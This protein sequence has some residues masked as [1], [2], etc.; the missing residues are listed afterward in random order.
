MQLT[1]RQILLL[2]LLNDTDVAEAAKLSQLLGVS[3][4][5]LKTELKALGPPLRKY[6][7]SVKWLPG[8]RIAVRGTRRLPEMIK[9]TESWRE[10]TNP[11]QILLIL[12][13]ADSFLTIQDIAD[14]LYMSKSFTEKALTKVIDARDDI[15]GLRHYGIRYT[16]SR[17]QRRELFAELLMPYM[18]GI[19]FILEL[20]QF[21]EQHFPL[22]EYLSPESIAKASDAADTL[23]SDTTIHL[24]DDSYCVFFLHLLFMLNEG[25][26]DKRPDPIY[27]GL[28]SEYDR[29]HTYVKLVGNLNDSADLR[30]S[31]N[32]SAYLAGLLMSLRKTR[33]LNNTEIRDEMQGF[34][35]TLFARIEDTFDLSLD[36][37]EQ[38]REG[39]ALH[40]Y[41]TAVRRSTIE[42]YADEKQCTEIKKQYPLAFDMAVVTAEMMNEDYDCNLKDNETVYLGL[43]FQ[44]ALE[45]RKKN[46]RKI[47]TVLVCHLGFAASELIKTKLERQ[48]PSLDFIHAYALQ[49]YL[50]AGP[51]D[52]DLILTTEKIP[53][54]D[55]PLIY[56]SAGLTE[57]EL[58]SVRIFVDRRQVDDILLMVLHEADLVDLNDCSTSEEAICR[59]AQNLIDSENV[60]PE[61]LK[62]LLDREKISSTAIHRI[63]VP[64][65]N[66]KLVTETKLL[67][68][69][70]RDGIEWDGET[71]TCVFMYAFTPH[72]VCKTEDV[73]TALFRK[74]ASP[75]V[76]EEI[77]ELRDLSGEEFKKKLIKAIAEG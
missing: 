35:E 57:N 77:Y 36:E 60:K 65:G 5:T 20:S 11:E 59:M 37:D 46:I 48:N 51:G 62:S 13:L 16:G 17:Q 18:Y 38:L 50:K 55:I 64:H 67:I 25:E 53:E 58:N 22:L 75:E 66:P 41:T 49:E 10:L 63:A 23:R 34:I 52:A 72:V 56:V 47:R 45:R 71:I 8:S 70:S 28:I 44:A 31:E 40:I 27:S 6:G 32:D 33:M 7:V 54:T 39:L 74:L 69:L 4:Q 14:R 29:N 73:Y 9:Q 2:N 15:E 43:H 26:K 61:Y 24:T 1:K 12:V 21:D 19:N 76:E 30:L 3:V 42:I 68:G